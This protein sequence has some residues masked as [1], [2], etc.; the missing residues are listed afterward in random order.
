VTFEHLL[1]LAQVLH[2]STDDYLKYLLGNPRCIGEGMFIVY[3]IGQWD[4]APNM[5]KMQCEHSTKCILGFVSASG[6][7]HWWAK[8]KMEMIHEDV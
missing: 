2:S 4:L 6:I 3:K 8:K 5:A 7:E 1:K